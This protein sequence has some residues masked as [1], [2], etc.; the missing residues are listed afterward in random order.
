M[1]LCHNARD[2]N[3]FLIWVIHLLGQRTSLS[4]L[5]P[6][7]FS[8]QPLMCYAPGPLISPVSCSHLYSCT[9]FPLPLCFH[10]FFHLS[11][12]P[13]LPRSTELLC[14]NSSQF[15]HSVY[16]SIK[17]FSR[18]LLMVFRMYLFLPQPFIFCSINCNFTSLIFDSF[19]KIYSFI[20]MVSLVEF[21]IKHFNK[22]LLTLIGF[23]S[24]HSFT[25]SAFLTI[26]S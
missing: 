6:V 17:L 9:F 22:L 2:N 16:Y 10:L 21:I 5:L 15:L 4:H 24:I 12:P 1:A 7:D 3:V 26:N 14:W 25:F 13:G 18:I 23:S 20:F 8:F 19:F 11:S